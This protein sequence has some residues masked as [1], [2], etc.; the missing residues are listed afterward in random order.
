MNKLNNAEL[1]ELFETLKRRDNITV[2]LM[3]MQ[4]E[5]EGR[6][7]TYQ[8]FDEAIKEMNDRAKEYMNLLKGLYIFDVISTYD[9]TEAVDNFA[10]YLNPLLRDVDQYLRKEV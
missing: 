8:D 9:F 2:S 4:A 1:Y 10:D 6:E 7:L 3:K 5:E